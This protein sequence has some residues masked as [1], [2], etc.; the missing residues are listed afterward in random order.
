[1]KS[2]LRYALAALALCFASSPAFALIC[3]TGGGCFWVGGTGTWDNSTTTHWASTSGGVGSIAVP[4]ATDAV[5]FD[6]SSGGGTV[7]VAATINGSNTIISLTAD[8][9]T[10]TIDL[11][12][13]NPSLTAATFSCSG[14]AVKTI[15][16]GTGTITATGTS[17][18]VFNFTTATNLTWTNNPVFKMAATPTGSRTFALIKSITI[19]SLE[20]ADTGSGAAGYI[21]PV[22]FYAAV[23][24]ITT[25]I[26]TTARWVFLQTG[27]Q[28][29]ITNGFTWNGTSSA[30]ILFGGNSTTGSGTGWILNGA[31]VLTWAGVVMLNKAGSGSITATN[32][33]DLGGNNGTSV[34]ITAPTTG[35]GSHCIGC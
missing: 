9:F 12:A 31:V 25:F 20:I 16:W 23:P 11:S 24:T 5:T 34:S 26:P 21:Y 32:S 29:V 14:A 22:I 28:L 3:G 30:P 35:G 18:T 27:S 15:V 2:F 8:A 6:A 19:A 1:M 33:F 7:T 13:N 4:S 17:G 10:G